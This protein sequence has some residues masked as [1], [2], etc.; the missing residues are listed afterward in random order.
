MRIAQVAP[1]AESVPPKLYGGTERV[2]AWLVGELVKL[3][4]DVT[5]FASGHSATSVT[6]IPVWRRALRLGRPR[7]DPAVAQTA[8]LQVIAQHAAAFDVVHCH[9]DSERDHGHPDGFRFS[10][11]P[12]QW[13]QRPASRASRGKAQN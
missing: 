11:L 9:T 12:T 7:S 1:L 6:L 2:I 4:H 3:G 13:P 5:L 8:L 10:K